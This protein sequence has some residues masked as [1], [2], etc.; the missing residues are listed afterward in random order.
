MVGSH[1][2]LG[3][4]GRKFNHIR[5]PWGE[6]CTTAS[7]RRRSDSTVGAPAEAYVSNSGISDH[8]ITM[9]KLRAGF[10]MGAVGGDTWQSTWPAIE[11]WGQ[12]QGMFRVVF[13]RYT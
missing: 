6:G 3:K 10:R 8:A 9:R 7:S 1:R 12:E 4:L 13:R 5:L 2:S 11:D